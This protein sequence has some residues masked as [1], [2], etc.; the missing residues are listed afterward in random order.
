M[1]KMIAKVTGLAGHCAA[2][3]KAGDQFEISCYQPNGICGFLL[4]HIFPNLQTF[5]FGGKM[6]WWN[7]KNLYLECPDPH[8]RLT[9]T[10]EKQ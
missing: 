2:G 8:N 4:H 5:E 9:M 1:P 7:E 10:I 6:P 3:H